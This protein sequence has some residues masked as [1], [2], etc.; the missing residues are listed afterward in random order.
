MTRAFILV[1]DSLGIGAAPDAAAFGDVGANTLGHIAQWR[2][3]Q[4]RPLH[5]PHLE[6]LG[7]GAA[8]HSAAGAWPDGLARRDGF[9]AAHAAAAERSRGKDTPSGHWEMTGCPVDFDWGYFP[10]TVPCFPA[11]LMAQWHARCGLSGSLGQCHASGTEIIAQLGDEHVRT[12]LPIVYTSSDSVFQVAAHEQHF[13]L[14]RLLDICVKAFEL[15]QP[16]N[17]ARV[18]ARP[19]AGEPGA[20]R[21][22]HH[23]KDFAIAPPAP[24]LLDAAQ[25]QGREVVALGKIGDIFA[26]RGVSTL[27]KGDGNAALF[28]RLLEQVGTAPDGALVFANFVDFDQN[29]G[30]RRDVDGY[31]QALEA[32]DARLPALR[33]TLRPGD[34]CV[35]TAD[36]G[37]DPTWPGSDHTR[38]FVPQLFFGPGVAPRALA[39][40]SS[41]CD[42]GQT[43]AAHLGLPPLSH[44]TV[45]ALG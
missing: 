23:R 32:F 40:R 34:L 14:P 39:A 24:T 8:M 6:A 41:F 27:I 26:M 30:H 12:G 44:G 11:E 45:C 28:D 4:G 37:C 5:I 17:I 10:R 31:A 7:L 43:L 22:T 1:A 20:Y 36:H 9:E 33:Q 13:G 18:I 16:L 19:F 42:L 21:R 38:E 3:R 2:V 29:F 35:I 25:A 15:L